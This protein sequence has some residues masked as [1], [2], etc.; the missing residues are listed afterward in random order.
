MTNPSSHYTTV[1]SLRLHYVEAGTPDPGNPPIVLLHGFPTSSHLYRNVIPELEKTHRVIALD[2]PGYGLS[3]KPLDV[4]YDYKFYAGV[5][6]GFLDALGID[7][8]DLVVHD[9]GGP[10]GLYWAVEN[11]SR[12]RRIVVLNTLVYPELHWA[13]K[14]FLVALRTPLLRDYLV[15]PKALVGVMKVGV[16]HKD[17][18]NRE[19]LTPYTA[20]FEPP[21]ARKALLQAG[22][23]LGAGGLAKIAKKLPTLG[24]PIRCIYGEKDLALPDVAKTMAR[25]ARDCP[26]TEVTALPNC[27]HFLQEDEPETVGRLM[28][29]FLGS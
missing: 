8:I 13:V 25:V 23:G 3:D 24:I 16:V 28:A 27:G 2:L 29:Q 17:R 10:V 18:M 19:V 26:G 1:D 11:P 21:A 14:L 9:L 20:P 15:S 4:A 12:V 22:S 6:S 7:T 5:L